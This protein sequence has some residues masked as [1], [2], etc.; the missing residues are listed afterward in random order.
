[1]VWAGVVFVVAVVLAAAM[2]MLRRARRSDAAESRRL[3]RTCSWAGFVLAAVPSTAWLVLWLSGGEPKALIGLAGLVLSA[4]PVI[5]GYRWPRLVVP[6]LVLCLLASIG[7]ALA[8]RHL[9][10]L[11]PL[12]VAL[13]GAWLLALA[14]HVRSS[15]HA[16]ADETPVQRR[17][18]TRS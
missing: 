6:S 14:L 4:A 8:W 1:M 13:T 2:T 5:A 18:T 12:A 10:V 16:G 15:T 9:Y 11:L 3:S 17:D 7:M